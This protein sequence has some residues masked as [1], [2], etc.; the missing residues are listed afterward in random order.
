MKW[1]DHNTM[2]EAQ[3]GPITIWPDYKLRVVEHYTLQGAMLSVGQALDLLMEGKT[4]QAHRCLEMAA[5]QL[6][7]VLN[8]APHVTEE[9]ER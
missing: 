4:V 7:E 8:E 6:G 2:A 5:D 9:V 1:V 3:Y